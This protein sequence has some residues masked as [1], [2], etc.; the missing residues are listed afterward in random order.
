MFAVDQ[1]T[2]MA[3]ATL[4][5]VVGVPLGA[6]LYFV[7]RVANVS[8]LSKRCADLDAPHQA[9][10]AATESLPLAEAKRRAT[11]LLHGAAAKLVTVSAPAEC[12]VDVLGDLAPE[13][14]SFLSTY[15][16][17]R[18]EENAAVV[19]HKHLA[20]FVPTELETL[21]WMP[22]AMALNK[23]DDRFV[24]IGEDPAICVYFARLDGADKTVY[25]ADYE[26]GIEP[27]C[28]SVY[29]WVLLTHL[30]TVWSEKPGEGV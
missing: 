7:L 22:D 5:L 30:D 8:C 28:A 14:R 19:G 2:L 3:A 16:A 26:W 21:E 18:F 6:V 17:V 25:R 4:I 20:P 11:E 15:G 10:R 27:D 9:D 1:W 24:Q 13:M 12:L 29:H 23:P